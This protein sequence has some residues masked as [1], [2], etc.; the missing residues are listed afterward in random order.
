MGC[1]CVWKVFLGWLYKLEEN[2]LKKKTVYRD[3]SII[4]HNKILYSRKSMK[5]SWNHK[6]LVRK[7]YVFGQ[8]EHFNY[9][10]VNYS[11]Q[12]VFNL[13]FLKFERYEQSTLVCHNQVHA[14]FFLRFGFQF[15]QDLLL[16]R[17]SV[18][19]GLFDHYCQ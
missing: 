6:C 4:L 15:Y 17:A 2:W 5:I 9:S 13:P 11:K 3:E 1:Q 10:Y 18:H 12:P 14:R 7:Q 8:R 16:L 19:L